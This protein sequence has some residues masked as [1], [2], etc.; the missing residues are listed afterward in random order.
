MR[1]QKNAYAKRRNLRRKSASGAEGLFNFVERPQVPVGE[2]VLNVLPCYRADMLVGLGGL[3]HSVREILCEVG[4]PRGELAGGFHVLNFDCD[5][6]LSG[7]KTINFRRRILLRLHTSDFAV[8]L[9]LN[10]G[11]TTRKRWDIVM[12]DQRF[13]PFVETVNPLTRVR[14]LRATLGPNRPDVGGV[15][16]G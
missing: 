16:Y 10:N 6:G 13:V 12:L 8:D 7:D 5:P 15:A 4:Y 3:D 14:T 9:A 11:D 1:R 2:L